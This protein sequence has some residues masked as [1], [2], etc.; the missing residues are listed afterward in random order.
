MP[1]NSDLESYLRMVFLG[2]LSVTSGYVAL[3]K[4]LK[5]ITTRIVVLQNQLNK[6]F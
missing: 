2:T 5:G 6:V 4:I 3:E 1:K